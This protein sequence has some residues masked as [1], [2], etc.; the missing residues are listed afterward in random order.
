MR[1]FLPLWINFPQNWILLLFKH[2]IFASKRNEWSVNDNLNGKSKVLR[3]TDVYSL[4]LLKLG[5]RFT[6][7]SQPQCSQ[8]Y[9]WS[10]YIQ[11]LIIR[12]LQKFAESANRSFWYTSG[13]LII[14]KDIHSF[15]NEHIAFQLF[16]SLNQ[17]VECI[18]KY[19]ADT[20]AIQ[21]LV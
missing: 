8:C 4:W 10:A 3:P 13:I 12:W 18:T 16:Y 7:N 2:Y 6:T 9:G 14:S 15:R 1:I 5:N 21:F 20:A 19:A 11:N 17:L